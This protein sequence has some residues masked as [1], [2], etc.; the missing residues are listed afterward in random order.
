MQRRSAD[1]PS[2]PG[3]MEPPPG[4]P[5]PLPEPPGPPSPGR[6]KLI[7]W[8]V[9]VGTV[10]ISGAV[11]TVVLLTGDAEPVAESADSGLPTS[12]TTLSTATSSPTTIGTIGTTTITDQ[13]DPAVGSGAIGGLTAA[14]SADLVLTV[15]WEDPGGEAGYNYV[16]TPGS[17]GALPADTTGFT[18]DLMPCGAPVTLTLT[19]VGSDGSALAV[20]EAT[21]AAVEC[22]AAESPP[23]DLR[24]EDGPE[25]D[26]VTIRWGDA[27]GEVSYRLL[28]QFSI[29]PEPLDA[30]L[31]A[32]RTEQAIP[33]PCGSGMNV[34]L[35]ALAADGREIGGV[36]TDHQTRA[37]NAWEWFGPVELVVSPPVSA[38]TGITTATAQ[39]PAGAQAIGGGYELAGSSSLTLDVRGWVVR[40]APAGSGWQVSW[41]GPEELDTQVWA[42]ALCLHTDRTTTIE[43]AATVPSGSQESAAA[44]CAPGTVLVGGG[45]WADPGLNVTVSMPAGNGWAV[46]AVDK[47]NVGIAR[48]LKAYAV[49][50]GDP[51]AAYATTVASFD[52]HPGAVGPFE[53]VDCPAGGILTGGGFAAA[54]SFFVSS[55][56]Y[57]DSGQDPADDNWL[58]RLRVYSDWDPAGPT[59]E[60][61]I[62]GMCLTAP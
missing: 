29:S 4:P 14:I 28:V 12:T 51:S 9:G 13:A 3:G 60:L 26:S 38:G 15:S 50:L 34:R 16:L 39:C 44:A 21:A 52:L 33:V 43:S 47:I 7:W 37:C 2:P 42:T 25:A 32:D 20:G 62:F 5:S 1:V 41:V 53:G 31:P 58:V 10:A 61:R 57:A 18:L 19:A 49:C 54:D 48:N 24:V 17:P 35:T 6:G 55:V 23:S 46:T 59:V 56:P 8:L 30:A 27:T 40:N 22:P 36:S 11:L 45:W